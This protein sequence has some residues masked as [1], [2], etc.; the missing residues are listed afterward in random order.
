MFQIAT[1]E[2]YQDGQIIFEEGSSGDWLYVIES[3]AVE[4]YKKVGGDKFVIEVL[5]PGDVFGEIAFF[6]KIPRTASAMAVGTATLGVID[7]T[8]LDEEFNRLSGD[9]R[10]LLKSLV[11]KLLKG[12]E[13]ALQPKL[14][15]KAPRIPK[16]LNLTYKSRE[17]F[18]K[19]LSSDLSSGGIFIK[20]LKPFPVGEQFVLNLTLPDTS[21]LL[22][23]RCKVSWNQTDKEDLAK[24]PQ[25]MGVEF[26]ELSPADRQRLKEELIKSGS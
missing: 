8:Y 6:A 23:I 7:R 14:H 12:N 17:G 11:L 19:A 15:R 22:K 4:I 10:M 3:G 18:I 20:T 16:V 1:E 9:F 26:I 24:H 21:E 5:Q 2:T 25:G 13:K